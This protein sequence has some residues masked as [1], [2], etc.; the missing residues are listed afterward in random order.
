M[1][2]CFCFCLLG[3]LS[4]G[5][6]QPRISQAQGVWAQ[7]SWLPNLYN[8]SLCDLCPSETLGFFGFCSNGPG[9]LNDTSL[10]RLMLFSFDPRLMKDTGSHSATLAGKKPT[11]NL[12]G[13]LYPNSLQDLCSILPVFLIDRWW[14]G[15]ILSS[16]SR[17]PPPPI[18]LLL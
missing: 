13:T 8:D 4:P 18:N 16:V 17:F 2:F 3:S 1:A 12:P 7:N 10:G 14:W 9:S 5:T 11:K 6:R 15:I